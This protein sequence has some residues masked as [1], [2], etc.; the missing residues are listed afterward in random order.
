MTKPQV[1]AQSE[2]VVAAQFDAYNAHDVDAFMTCWHA[3]AEY[4]AFP[5]DLLAA[6]ADAIRA[7]HVLRFED[8]AVKVELLNRIVVE[9]TVVDHELFTRTFPEGVGQVEVMAIYQLEGGLIRKAW[10]KQGTP[11]PPAS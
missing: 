4:F 8:A 7:R 9:T 3:E 11:R 1:S 2:Q 6:G 10:F 5:D